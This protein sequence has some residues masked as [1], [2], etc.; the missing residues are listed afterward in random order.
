MHI[1]PDHS[2]VDDVA[3]VFDASRVSQLVVDGRPGQV[4]NVAKPIDDL[5]VLRVV[6]DKFLSTRKFILHIHVN[7]CCRH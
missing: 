1:A 7:D 3:G 2:L 6:V 5:N 4:V